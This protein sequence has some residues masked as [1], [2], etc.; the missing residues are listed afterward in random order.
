MSSAPAPSAVV[1]DASTTIRAI[2]PLSKGDPDA[3][4][5]FITW[6]QAQVEIYAPEIWLAE[7]V[8]VIRQAVYNKWITDDEGR[9]AVEDVF[10][11][12]VEVLPSD[13][14]LCQ[15]ALTWASRLGQSKAYDGFYLALAERLSAE[16]WTADEKMSNRAGQLGADWV[17]W[18][19][20]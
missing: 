5:R 11:L 9:L 2:L 16:L 10:R 18:T 3:L 1:V 19:G 14:G 17:K 7:V 12:G 4:D 8:S 20:A 6:N 13:V 15:T